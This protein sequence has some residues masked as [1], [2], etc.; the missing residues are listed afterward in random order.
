VIRVRFPLPPAKPPSYWLDFTIT[1]LFP[2]APPPVGSLSVAPVSLVPIQVLAMRCGVVQTVRKM[3]PPG[4]TTR[5]FRS[6][7]S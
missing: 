1:M 2:A 6:K 5:F 4:G 7:A 3:V